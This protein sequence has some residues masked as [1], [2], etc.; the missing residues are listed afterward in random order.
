MSRADGSSHLSGI[1]RCGSIWECAVCQAVVKSTRAQ[2]IQSVAET[3][4]QERIVMLTLTIRHTRQEDLKALRQGLARAW[5]RVKSGAPWVRFRERIG[6]VGDVRA[7][8]VTH[9]E[10]NG[11]HPHLHIMIF[12]KL[13]ADSEAWR[14]ERDW[15]SERWRSAVNRELGARCIPSDANGATVTPCHRVDYI[16]KLGLEICDPGTKTANK[17]SRTPW[18]IAADFA[19]EKKLADASLFREYTQAMFRARQLTWSTGRHDLRK[20]YDVADQ[21]DTAIVEDTASDT[22]RRA[23]IPGPQWDHIRHTIKQ[24]KRGKRN[25]AAASVLLDALEIGGVQ[26]MWDAVAELERATPKPPPRQKWIEPPPEPLGEMPPL[27]DAWHPT[28]YSRRYSQTHEAEIDFMR[29]DLHEAINGITATEE[30]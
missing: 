10:K 20:I 27:E 5:S 23:A 2:T 11:W 17:A 29:L 19:R 28:R 30:A 1:L 13:P 14:V 4:G 26:R 25:P 3:H 6:Y 22:A 12:S 16:A 9:G 7:L 21:D 8:E 24:F 18:E 15:L